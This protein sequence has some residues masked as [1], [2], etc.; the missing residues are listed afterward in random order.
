MDA[1]LRDKITVENII[2]LLLKSDIYYNSLMTDHNI[3]HNIDRK[4]GVYCTDTS[5]GLLGVIHEAFAQSDFGRIDLL[6]A[7]SGH[8][9]MNFDS[10]F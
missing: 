6:P 4:K 2:E 8:S 9:Y 7:R 1:R 5:L 3:D 10:H